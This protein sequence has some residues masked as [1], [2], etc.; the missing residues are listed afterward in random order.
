MKVQRV[1]EEFGVLYVV[2]GS[3]R[4]AGGKLKI[5]ALLID[6]LTGRHLL[7][8]RYRDVNYQQIQTDIYST[9]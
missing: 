3:V 2:E 6:V 5:I 4:K 8:E 9:G 1:A 7:A